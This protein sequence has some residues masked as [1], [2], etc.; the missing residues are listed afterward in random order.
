M[1]EDLDDENVDCT[2]QPGEDS[3]EKKTR[4]P[5]RR[6]FDEDMSALT[7]HIQEKEA[8]LEKLKSNAALHISKDLNSLKAEKFAKIT[9]RKEIDAQ[10]ER[11]NKIIP[12]K[13][14]H[15]NQLELSLYYKSEE[16]INTAIGRLEWNL[17]VQSFK[18][19]EE[20]KIVSEID[21]LKR[22]KKVLAQYLTL[23][24]EINGI[25]DHQR[26]MREER[27]TLYRSVS[28]IKT[29][30]EKLR[31]NAGI[32]RAS[33]QQ[34]KREIDGLYETKRSMLSS[35]RKQKDEYNEVKEKQR[36]EGLKR[37]ESFLQDKR[38][39][40]AEKEAARV[41]FEEELHLCNTLIAYLGRFNT[42]PVSESSA[43]SQD[44]PEYAEEIDDGQYVL[45]KKA[46]EEHSGNLR[47]LS[48]KNRRSRKQTMVKQ[49]THTPEALSQFL[50]LNLEAPAST[51]DIGNI[52]DKL[53]A[54]KAQYERAQSVSP[55]ISEVA[56]DAGIS[57]TESLICEMSRQV[58]K[59][60]SSEE[61]GN[62]G[63]DAEHEGSKE[64][65]KI[66]ADMLLHCFGGSQSPCPRDDQKGLP[67][68]TSSSSR[69]EFGAVGGHAEAWD[70]QDGTG[71]N[72]DSTVEGDSGSSESQASACEV[73]TS[74]S[75]L[76]VS[77]DSMGGAVGG[78]SFSDDSPV[79]TK[80]E[81]SDIGRGKAGGNPAPLYSQM[82]L[83]PPREPSQRLDSQQMLSTASSGA[84]NKIFSPRGQ[85]HPPL[86]ASASSP[87]GLMQMSSTHQV[88]PSRQSQSMDSAH[89]QGK[90]S[91][92]QGK[93]GA[94]RGRGKDPVSV[95]RRSTFSG[96]AKEIPKFKESDKTAKQRRET[97]SGQRK[98]KEI[99]TRGKLDQGGD[100]LW[101]NL[102]TGS[103]LF[104]QTEPSAGKTEKLP[105]RPNQLTHE[106]TLPTFP[107]LSASWSGIA[108]G[109]IKSATS[110]NTTSGLWAASYSAVVS[111]QSS[112][113]SLLPIHHPTMG[114]GHHRHSL[115]PSTDNTQHQALASRV[116]APTAM[117]SQAEQELQK[118]PL[119]ARASFPRSPLLS[120]NMPR[121]ASTPV[122]D[123]PFAHTPLTSPMTSLSGLA[124]LGINEDF[125]PLS[126]SASMP[127]PPRRNSS[128]SSFSSKSVN[129]SMAAPVIPGTSHFQAHLSSLGVQDISQPPLAQYQA[130][131]SHGPS[132]T[133]SGVGKNLPG[134]D[135]NLVFSKQ[136]S[137]LDLSD[138]SALL[139]LAPES[140][141]VQ[142]V[143]RG[144]PSIS[145]VQQTFFSALPPSEQ[146]SVPQEI[147]TDESFTA[148]W[149]ESS[150]AFTDSPQH[151]ANSCEP[152]EY[153][154]ST[155][156]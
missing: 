84:R 93:G 67:E 102:A 7:S 147:P 51:A 156:L 29:R 66:Y 120:P 26:S 154:E 71:Q 40:I 62:E 46:D 122:S 125:P 109:S 12:E 3:F 57:A 54:L 118:M 21:G 77:S 5:N 31:K 72:S 116:S 37:R 145:D 18:L 59:T 123:S 6:K 20:K 13:M 138:P 152:S 91:S 42:Q 126:F 44:D 43:D 60:E 106:V 112:T 100:S 83:K 96:H 65:D 69:E 68:G 141:E 17:K 119:A 107:P 105:N 94:S 149:V 9:Q 2:L 70:S 87:A 129:S 148:R 23:K 47:K 63:V 10:L 137:D 130:T 85:R 33:V 139:P 48:R 92:G 52:L 50:T 136:T 155:N 58:S 135:N 39:R 132:F 114:R 90:V 110:S 143:A 11:I 115:Q 24:Q 133:E 89:S 8:E 151:S 108:S 56:S 113:N 28:Q 142:D 61:G 146:A 19:S 75:A 53:V 78:V 32:A 144:G 73:K 34:C 98:D 95:N 134:S 121:Q 79:E 127:A 30:E 16:K 104:S 131:S 101:K 111:P 36:Q 22:S 117:D 99:S 88:Q 1:E 35:Y 49:M 80:I 25:R 4:P 27:D 15:L 76:Q 81:Y 153:T 124:S 14:K 74:I 150:I 140:L 41:P 45:L 103:S 97:F 86:A 55:H 82:L 128:N 64:E 38:K